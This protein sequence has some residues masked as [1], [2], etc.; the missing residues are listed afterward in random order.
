MRLVFFCNKGLTFT[1][2]IDH[3]LESKNLMGI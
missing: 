3:R 1:V 2:L